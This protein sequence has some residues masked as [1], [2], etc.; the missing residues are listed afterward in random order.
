[1][2]A[3]WPG[4]TTKSVSVFT[5]YMAGDAYLIEEVRYDAAS[6]APGNVIVRKVLEQVSEPVRL[7]KQKEIDELEYAER[8]IKARKQRGKQGARA[9]ERAHR[10]RRGGSETARE[11]TP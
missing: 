5:R 9:M 7:G 11:R 1:M 10:Q 2:A 8:E 4:G 6:D 3:R